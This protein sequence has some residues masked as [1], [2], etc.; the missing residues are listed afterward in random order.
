[1]TFKSTTQKGNIVKGKLKSQ[2]ELKK[3]TSSD[4]YKKAGYQ[5]QNKMLNVATHNKGGGADM[6]IQKDKDKIS[7][8]TRTYALAQSMKNKDRITKKDL[9][10]AKRRT[11][12][13]L[14]GKTPS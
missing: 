2:K 3:I 1:M 6:G 9:E 11:Q 12:R 8:I 4:K 5:E 10:M 7:E 14:G 13:F